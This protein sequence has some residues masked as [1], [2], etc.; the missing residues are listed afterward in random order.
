MNIFANSAH[1]FSFG[2][3]TI[4]ICIDICL[5]IIIS[6]YLDSVWPT[7]ESPRRH[8][9]FIFGYNTRATT[10]FESDQDEVD[11][12]DENVET[13]SA[14]NRDDA[15]IDVRKMSKIWETTG[16]MAVDNLSFRAYRGQVTILLGHNGAGKSSTFAAISGST[17]VTA[18]NVYI[19]KEDIQSNLNSCQQKIGF[20]PQYNPLFGRLTVREHLR[21]YAQLKTLNKSKTLNSEIEMLAQQVQLKTK[22]DEVCL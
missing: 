13:D 4:M 11:A 20:C 15:D 8:P 18:G 6:L 9:L 22:L 5:M 2:F 16:Q 21:L 17:S 14:S 7:D 1:S 10:L 19:C 3:A 12:I